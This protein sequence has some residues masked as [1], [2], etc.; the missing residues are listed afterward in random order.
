MKAIRLLLVILLLVGCEPDSWKEN[1]RFENTYFLINPQD[2]GTVLMLEA[3]GGKSTVY[4]E[5]GEFNL[6]VFEEINNNVIWFEGERVYVN[7]EAD[8]LYYDG[9]KVNEQKWEN[10]DGV[11]Y[12]DMLLPALP[13][14]QKYHLLSTGID[15]WK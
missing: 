6:E 9:D 5:E 15:T 1:V 12:L 4:N 14:N 13:G 10:E 7:Y 2:M 11:H 3:D 8:Y